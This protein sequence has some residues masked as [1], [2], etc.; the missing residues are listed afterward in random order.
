MTKW[1]IKKDMIMQYHHMNEEPVY[2][3]EA[4]D[5]LM[6]ELLTLFRRHELTEREIRRLCGA[7]IDTEFM[8]NFWKNRA[9][10]HKANE[11]MT[12][13]EEDEELLLLK[14]ES[15]TKKIFEYMDFKK[16]DKLLDLGSGYGNWALR[17]ADKVD[18]VHAVDYCSEMVNLGIKRAQEKKINNIQFFEESIQEYT[19]NI[20]YDTIFIS[21]VL[22][23]LNDSD[24]RE[25]LKRMPTYTKVGTQLIIREGTGVNGRYIIDKEYSDRL[26]TTYSAIYRT[27][28]ELIEIFKKIGFQLIKDEDMFPEGSVLNKFPNTRLR[29]YKFVRK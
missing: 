23:Y 22:L 19:N 27:R 8:R 3:Q 26:E 28:E 21:G 5:R 9:N 4:I 11:S 13:L 16:T 10:T 20:K 29:I 6:D 12:N 25:I 24:I 1:D 2:P 18:F 15:E 7:E 17:F 14:I